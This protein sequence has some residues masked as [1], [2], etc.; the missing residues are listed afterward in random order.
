VP[1]PKLR[2]LFVIAVLLLAGCG[3]KASWNP[4]DWFGG[5]SGPQPA[6]LP[7]LSGAQT[8]RVLWSANVGEAGSF[9]FSP[10][11]NGDDVYAAG[12]GGTV[13]RLDAASGATRWRVTLD[14]ALSGGVGT[15]GSIVVVASEEGEVFALNAQDGALR[16][17]ARVSSEVLAAPVVGEG[18]ALVRSADSRVF[19]FD[20][21]DGKRRW[22][23]QR[24]A[25]ALVVRSP[26]GVTLV[27]GLALAGFSG[28]KIVA[29]A[30]SNGAARWEG[31]VSLPRGATELER[32]ADV[33]G[34]PAVLGREVC[35][36]AYQGKVTCFDMRSGNPIWSRGLS[37]VTG[38]RLDARSAYVSD[39]Q[40]A[41]HALERFSGRSLWKQDRLAHRRLSLPYAVESAVAVGDFEGYVHFLDRESGAFV[42][43]IATDGGAILAAPIRL[44]RGGFLVQTRNGGLFAL[45]L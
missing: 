5:S 11:L 41:V 13:A 17:K 8:V 44:S 34:E 14:A 30:L 35:A 40:G 27:P 1:K 6:P 31:T 3:G 38:V 37:S 12:R 39:D 36:A 33:V 15:D 9:A 4:L 2:A 16:W 19:A 43:R 28:G 22:V 32:V 10:A 29:L 24:A 23:Y 7:P 20:T 26:A 18:L 25:S 21:A 45:S 42:A